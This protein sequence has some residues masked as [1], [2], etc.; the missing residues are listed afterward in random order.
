MEE[1]AAPE[2]LDE[3]TSAEHSTRAS[4]SSAS[5]PYPTTTKN[6]H[7]QCVFSRPVLEEYRRS[8]EEGG[9]D[10]TPAPEAPPAP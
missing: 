4:Q 6:S 5:E 7:T 10:P 2:E 1:V 8:R 9:E 3:A